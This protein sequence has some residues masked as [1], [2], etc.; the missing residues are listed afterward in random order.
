MKGYIDL[1]HARNM[2]AMN[3]NLIFGAYE[4]A[5]K[6]GVKREWGLF[7][8]PSA[9]NQDKHPLPEG[10]ASDIMLYDPSNT[11]WQNYLISKEA[12]V[13]EHLPFDGWHVDQLG[14]RGGLWN[15]QEKVSNCLKDTFPF[16]KS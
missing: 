8:D 5:E 16:E 6:D 15:A 10:W 9:T 1:V 11:E 7:K 13:F 4:D 12:E 14:D 3:Y 2:K